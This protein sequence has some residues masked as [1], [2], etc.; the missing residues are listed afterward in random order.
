MKTAKVIPLFKQGNKHLYTN[1]RPVSL[2]SQFSKILEKLF[3]S[4]LEDFLNKHQILN[5][6]QYG[7]RAKSTTSLALME[8]K[9]EITNAL[10][11]GKYAVGVFI[12]LKKA[13]DTINHSILINKL[14][15][16]GVR[17]VALD[18]ITSYLSGRKQFVEMG[19][20]KSECM[21]VACG[22]P[23]G[24]ILGPKLF[25]I[26]INDIFLVSKRLKLILFADDTNILYFG[27]EY[28]KVIDTI[29]NE[30]NKVKKWMDGN[31][32]SLNIEKTKV[33]IF[34]NYRNKDNE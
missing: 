9:E 2:L 22:V 7:F 12:D 23:Q 16:Y 13:F 34:G 29:N 8:V 11:Q 27:N 28:S 3:N 31:K 5:Q 26:Y 30:L 15:L 25:N 33:I 14:Q 10:D 6:S 32:L 20:Y 24:S 17:G 19:E 1:Y 4:R 18:W 21:E